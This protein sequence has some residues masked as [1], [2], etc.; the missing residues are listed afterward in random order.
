MAGVRPPGKVSPLTL[1]SSEPSMLVGVGAVQ[2]P[3]GCPTV[4]AARNDCSRGPGPS[5]AVRCSCTGGDAARDAYRCA[6]RRKAATVCG[7]AVCEFYPLP[8]PA[9]GPRRLFRGLAEAV[10]LRRKYAVTKDAAR[11]R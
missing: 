9:P 4:D 2:V 6:A 7:F 5:G 11:R 10:L 8:H 3:R 1:K